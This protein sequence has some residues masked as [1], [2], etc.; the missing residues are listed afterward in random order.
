[1]PTIAKTEY[2][3]HGGTLLVAKPTAA[4][5]DYIAHH[6][7]S[8]GCRLGADEFFTENGLY[9]HRHLNGDLAPLPGGYTTLL[10]CDTA[11]CGEVATREDLFEIEMYAF[12]G[13]TGITR[14]LLPQQRGPLA[15]TAGAF[16]G[17]T[18]LEE[19]TLPAGT[20]YDYNVLLDCRSL[21]RLTLPDGGADFDDDEDETFDGFAYVAGLVEQL[22]YETLAALTLCAPA[23]SPAEQYARAQGLAFEAL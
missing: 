16:A 3:T 1:M 17:C 6:Y 12:Y 7:G 13:C 11:A 15:L 23:G 8:D 20:T 18:A 5:V 22:P 10:R 4:F 19:L 21:R 2:R 14:I 9:Y